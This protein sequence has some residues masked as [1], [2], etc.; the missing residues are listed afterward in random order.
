VCVCVTICLHDKKRLKL[1]P[2][3]LAQRY[4]VTITR[5][6]INIGSKGQGHMSQSAKRRS[7]GR[8][9]LCT[10]SSAQPLL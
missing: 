4:S 2:P 5:P 7:S 9:E 6:P 10:L 1:N 8:R 3:N